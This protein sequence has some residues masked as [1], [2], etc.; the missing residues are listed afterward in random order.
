MR[1]FA[2]LGFASLVSACGFAGSPFDGFGGFIGDTHN[3]YRNPNRPVGNSETML[4]VTG[5]EVTVAPLEPE[6]GNIWPG[7]QP[8]EPTL[9]DIERQQNTTAPTP[10]GPGPA[11]SGPGQV[12]P[13]QVPPG[14]ILR[15]QPRVVPQGSSTPPS[16]VPAVGAPPPAPAPQSYA[17]APLYPNGPSSPTINT[18][19]GPATTTSG[20][21]GITTYTVP[22]GGTGIVVPN[23]NGTNTLV[24]PDGSVQTV[25]APR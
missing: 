6:A 23:G 10:G 14:T 2:L 9:E 5:R 13:G 7:P 22:G 12:V 17:P 24:G 8:P 25:P 18:P 15:G 4:R 11:L 20:G 19:Q 21:N 16:Q 1:R 3:I